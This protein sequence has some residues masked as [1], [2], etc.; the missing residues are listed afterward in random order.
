MNAASP[1]NIDQKKISS[2]TQGKETIEIPVKILLM[3]TCMNKSMVSQQ[4]LATV[5]TCIV[6]DKNTDHA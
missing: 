6:V 3:S 1:R 5:M 4:I 2:G